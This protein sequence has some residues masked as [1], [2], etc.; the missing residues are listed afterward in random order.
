M[1]AITTSSSINVNAGCRKLVRLKGI[2]HREN[3][4]SDKTDKF[5]ILFSALVLSNALDAGSFLFLLFSL[6]L[7]WVAVA[8]AFALPPERLH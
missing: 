7:F 3:K 2:K 4:G 5:Q 1:I 6:G 8:V